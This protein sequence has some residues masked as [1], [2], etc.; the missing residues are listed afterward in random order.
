MK[1]N[2]FSVLVSGVLFLAGVA[3]NDN[4]PEQQAEQEGWGK[5][6][7]SRLDASSIDIASLDPVA[8]TYFEQLKVAIFA[9]GS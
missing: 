9:T 3:C 5:A 7:S 1:K 4:L 2:V 8:L 6:G